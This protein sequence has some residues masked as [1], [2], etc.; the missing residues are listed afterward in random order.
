MRV[1]T[2][3]A[4]GS[5]LLAAVLIGVLGYF[6]L[7]VRQ[8]VVANQELTAVHFRVTT[9]ALDLLHQVDQIEVNAR[10]FYVTRDA[11]YADRVARARDDFAA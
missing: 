10:K 8:L 4:T 7:L 3:V 9:V 11:A 6:V 1:A 5:G 2:K